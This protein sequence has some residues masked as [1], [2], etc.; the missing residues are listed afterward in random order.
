MYASDTYKKPAKA[1]PP[2]PT[3]IER[4]TTAPTGVKRKA[5]RSMKTVWLRYATHVNSFLTCV[6]QEHLE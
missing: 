3:A 4:K 1:K 6:N 2:S 5:A